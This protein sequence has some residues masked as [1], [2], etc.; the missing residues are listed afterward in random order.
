MAMV[1]L[2]SAAKASDLALIVT[3]IPEPIA[4]LYMRPDNPD[5]I[6]TLAL[7]LGFLPIAAAFMVFDAVQVAAN[8][9]L[10]GLK[11]VKAPM[12]ITGISFWGLGFP[13]C[14]ILA[15]HTPLRENGVWYGLMIGLIAAFIG[16]GIRLLRQL[17]QPPAP[18]SLLK[19]SLSEL[20]PQ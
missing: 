19:A 7:I 11:D 8:Q 14:Y 1:V 6:A 15:F 9:L 10:R 18:P 3:L 5:N 4:H 20:A 13:A 16:L 12:I 2:A 17:K